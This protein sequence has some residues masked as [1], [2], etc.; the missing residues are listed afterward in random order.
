ML[1][2][3][4]SRI[5]DTTNEEER[6]ISQK[7]NNIVNN[8]N[9]SKIKMDSIIKQLKPQLQSD[10]D[11]QDNAEKQNEKVDLRLKKNLFDA[12]IKKYQNTLQRFQDEEGE[13]MKV[14]ETKIVRGAE[15]A[16][17]QELD[18]QE[19]KRIIDNPQ[20][21]QQIYEDRLKQKA[22]VRL[23]NAVRDLEERHRDI[24]N[25]EK[26]I[27]ELHKMIMQLNILVQYQGEMI[28]NIVEN[29][30]KAK[31]YVIKGEVNINKGEKNMKCGRKIKCI[32]MIVVISILLV[33]LIP[34]IIKF[35]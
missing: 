29:V 12:M 10:P 18:E 16:L 19:R 23:I 11:I 17:G 31:D 9:N 25:L 27:L 7:L 13:I 26:S 6:E 14:K 22:H 8:V 4:K 34:I 20:I 24:K 1:I 5:I 28:D 2:P 33:I 35:I 3:I 30:S 15:I 32:I 21:V